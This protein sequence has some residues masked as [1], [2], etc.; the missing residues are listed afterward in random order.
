MKTWGGLGLVLWAVG[1]QGVFASVVV[2]DLSAAAD[3]DIVYEGGPGTQA[4]GQNPFGSQTLAADGYSDGSTAA[5]G[6]PVSRQL[7]ST[8]AGLG[9]YELLPYEGNNAIELYTH[10]S[11]PIESH[12]IDVPDLSYLTIGLLVSAVEGDA[13]FTFKL[14]YLDGTETGWW[15]AD[16]WYETGG[17]LRSSQHVVIDGLDRVNINTGQVE[18]SNHFSLYE[19]LIAPDAGRV[20]TSI[21]IGNDP[22]RWPD[23][24][25]RW[26]GVFAM[27]GEAVDAVPEPATLIFFGIGASLLYWQRRGAGPGCAKKA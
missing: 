24:T 21:T 16:D 23:N 6:L 14:N 11:G 7:A 17:L 19:Y 10:S 27:N 12:V 8:H 5:D 15:E 13:S 22:N 1:C 26:A 3:K 20:L 18:D 4:F 2:F 25:E 9:S